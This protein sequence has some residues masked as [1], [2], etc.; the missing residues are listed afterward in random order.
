MRLEQ[1]ARHHAK[2]AAAA[3]QRPEEIGV[4]A[5]A[6]RDKTAVGQDNVRF[7]QV[8]DREAVLAREVPGAPA[9]GEARDA[10]GRDDAKGHGQSE[11]VG[12]VI[13]VAR[14]AASINPNGSARRIYAHALHHR[15]VD[16]Q[17]VVATAKAWAI[18]AAAPD[19]DEQALVAAEVHRGDDVGDVHAARNQARPLVDHAV[20]KSTGGIVVSITW[21]DESSAKALLKGGHD[22]IS[23]SSLSF[24]G[25]TIDQT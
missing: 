3:A 2:V 11:R 8:V 20:V 18:V 4:L 1:E 7:E 12:G 22:L 17:S 24:M 19:G 14:R 15:E 23:H 9:E 6:G 21:T 16:H 10:G 13:D 25:Y 5:L